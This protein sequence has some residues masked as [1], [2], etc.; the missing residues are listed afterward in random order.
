[1]GKTDSVQVSYEIKV[2]EN[3]TETS[4]RGRQEA[5]WIGSGTT[6]DNT[7]G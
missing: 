2:A 6:A 7:D 5:N 3:E 4:T 1:V